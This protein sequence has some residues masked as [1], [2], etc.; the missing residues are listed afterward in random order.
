MAICAGDDINSLRDDLEL[1]T[2]HLSIPRSLSLTPIALRLRTPSN[3]S[4]FKYVI[5]FLPLFQHNL[6][7][8]GSSIPDHRH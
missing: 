4:L 2:E 7:F 6:D 3:T 1:F 5:H 8:H